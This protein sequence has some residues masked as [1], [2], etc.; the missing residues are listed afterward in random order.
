MYEGN[1]CLKM[2]ERWRIRY[3]ITRENG[4]KNN[5]RKFDIITSWQILSRKL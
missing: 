4:W 5:E 1:T 3:E 2:G